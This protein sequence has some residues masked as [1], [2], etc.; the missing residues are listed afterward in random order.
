[1]SIVLSDHAVSIVAVH[2]LNPKNTESHAE[3][4]WTSEKTNKLWLRDFLPTKIPSARI[5]IFGYNSN[6]AFETS[7]AGLSEHAGNLLNL[8]HLER[9]VCR[10]LF[11]L[12]VHSVFCDFVGYLKLIAVSYHLTDHWSSYVIVLVV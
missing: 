11:P 4:T 2:G 10:L 6:V 8:L 12:M 9:K 7:S 5:F 3:K 1:M